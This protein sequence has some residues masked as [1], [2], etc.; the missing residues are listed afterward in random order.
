MTTKARWF[1][2]FFL[3]ALPIAAAAGPLSTYMVEPCRFV[4]TREEAPI[5]GVSGPFTGLRLYLVQGRCGVA[6]GARGLLLNVTA[7]GATVEGHLALSS[8]EITRNEG[9]V[10]PKTSTLN[11]EPGRSVANFAMVSLAEIADPTTDSDLL[12]Y[13][14]VPGGS[15]HVI[16]DVVGYLK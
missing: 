5:P 15:V 13:V 8:S 1:G 11:F 16:I 9:T 6:W 2:T 12:V 14:H 7:T 10:V 4:D 3:A